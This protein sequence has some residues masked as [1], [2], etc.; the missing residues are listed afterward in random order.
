MR[1]AGNER[2]KAA[3]VLP[4]LCPWGGEKAP[5]GKEFL[6]QAGKSGKHEVITTFCD[7]QI[8]SGAH[9]S[10]SKHSLI[11]WIFAKAFVSTRRAAGRFF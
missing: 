4:L 5:Q 1:N 10:S 3:L 9:L 6:P 7:K 11:D 2:T 8:N